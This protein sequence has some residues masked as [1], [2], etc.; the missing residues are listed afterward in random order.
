MTKHIWRI[1]SVDDPV[2]KEHYVMDGLRA[3]RCW[4]C[5]RCGSRFPG[6]R[7]H[8][9]REE[10]WDAFKRC[11]EGVQLEVPIVDDC[12]AVLIARVHSV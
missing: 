2:F 6:W 7:E 8:E 4:I 3:F 5:D 1:L 9:T 12:D 10:A 11:L